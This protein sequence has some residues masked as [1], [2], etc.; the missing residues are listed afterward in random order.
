MDGEKIGCRKTDAYMHMISI[1]S[2]SN[3]VCNFF[4]SSKI[5]VTVIKLYTSTK[6]YIGTN[7]WPSTLINMISDFRLSVGFAL[8]SIFAI[9]LFI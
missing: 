1:E 9:Y 2:D 5:F 6:A 7:S 3:H 8:F 4:P